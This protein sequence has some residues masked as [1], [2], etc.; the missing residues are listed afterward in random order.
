MLCT[1]LDK[2]SIGWCTGGG[3]AIKCIFWLFEF[4]VRHC[5][6]KQ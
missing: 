4:V 1:E 6:L 5:E 3:G 2:R